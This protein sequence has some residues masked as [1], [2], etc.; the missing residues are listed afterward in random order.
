V[1]DILVGL[2]SSKHLQP[3]RNDCLFM[4]V[5]ITK[6]AKVGQLSV[7]FLEA[8]LTIPSII[9]ALKKRDCFGLRANRESA[10]S[11]FFTSFNMQLNN[12]NGTISEV[13]CQRWRLN[14]LEL[15]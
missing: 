11:L 9:L 12:K 10:Y 8:W 3:E 6:S 2:A 14:A 1:I 13:R 15:S 4:K 5:K 7:F